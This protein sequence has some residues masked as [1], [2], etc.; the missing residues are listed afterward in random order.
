MRV[1][2]LQR[3]LP[4]EH[5]INPYRF[6]NSVRGWLRRS[7]TEAIA[8]HPGRSD[9][10]YAAQQ[11]LHR[12]L[13]DFLLQTPSRQLLK[14]LLWFYYTTAILPRVPLVAEQL[15]ASHGALLCVDFGASDCRQ[16][17]PAVHVHIGSISKLFTCAARWAFTK[18]AASPSAKRRTDREQET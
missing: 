11:E 8:A 13:M 6:E 5:H 4:L 7:R 2:N 10:S 15:C 3:P 17:R 18:H 14:K 16:I 12:R 1:L 9:L